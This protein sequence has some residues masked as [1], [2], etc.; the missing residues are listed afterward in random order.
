MFPPRMKS[1]QNCADAAGGAFGFDEAD[2]EPRYVSPV[3]PGRIAAMTLAIGGGTLAVAH[4]FG[5]TTLVASI[6]GWRAA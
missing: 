4:H 3:R 2:F 6:S 1:L 5:W